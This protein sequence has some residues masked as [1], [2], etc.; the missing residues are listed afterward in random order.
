[1]N[2]IKKLFHNSGFINR[3]ILRKYNLSLPKIKNREKVIKGGQKFKD[4][5]VIIT[6]ASSGIGRACAFEFADNGAI[7]VLA[8]RREDELK[9]VEENINKLGGRAVAIKTDVRVIDDCIN[10]IDKTIEKYGKI[11]VLINNAGI[12]MRASF[13]DMDLVVMKE[14]M[15]TN[16]YGAV[17]CTKF[18]LPYLLKQKGTIIG[19]SSISG[20]TPLP[21]RTGYSA[22]KH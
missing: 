18:A 17:Y 21:G 16:F 8:A 22:S 13:E 1:M 15:D 20:L 10:L 3:R 2:S 14:L 7:V 11:D 5:V 6:G 9:K 4:K 19:I 12:S